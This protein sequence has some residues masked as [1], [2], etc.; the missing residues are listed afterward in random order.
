[1]GIDVPEP[2]RVMVLGSTRKFVS[3]PC[4]AFAAALMAACR[5]LGLPVI[6]DAS[7]A[8]SRSLPRLFDFTAWE[9]AVT[10]STSV[11]SELTLCDD[12]FDL[13]G[14][15]SARGAG[16]PLV[17]T[18]VVSNEGARVARVTKGLPAKPRKTSFKNL[19]EV[20][21]CLLYTSPS[22]RDR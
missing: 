19:T 18:S 13:G 1:M 9:N 2:A 16:A 20:R 5:R 15:T 21:A 10:E 12:Q 6:S 8:A 22:P 7:V 4:S 17:A 3:C 11:R 14:A